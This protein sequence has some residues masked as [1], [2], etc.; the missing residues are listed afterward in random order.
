MLPAMSAIEEAIRNAGGVVRMASTLGTSPSVVSNWKARGRVP[1]DWLRR[2]SR[3][4]QVAIERLLPDDP[5]GPREGQDDP[6][7]G[8]IVPVETA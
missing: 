3:V 5:E 6:D 4:G 2:F 7:T 1:S 8:R